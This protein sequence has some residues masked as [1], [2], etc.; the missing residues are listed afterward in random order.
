M[1]RLVIEAFCPTA[2]PP[3]SHVSDIRPTRVL[4]RVRFQG[5]GTV[6]RSQRLCLV[7]QPQGHLPSQVLD[8]L[9]RSVVL[10]GP[11]LSAAGSARLSLSLC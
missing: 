2:L 10:L 6:C 4:E 5:Q 3:L 7:A 8:W 9:Q 11:T 1:V